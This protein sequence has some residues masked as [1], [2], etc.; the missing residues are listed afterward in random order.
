MQESQKQQE[1]R[2]QAWKQDLEEKISAQIQDVRLEQE[3]R[4]KQLEQPL[5]KMQIVILTLVVMLPITIVSTISLWLDK[6]PE[7][8]AQI[9]TNYL[10]WQERTTQ[11][12]SHQEQT[13]PKPP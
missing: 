11:S 2:L 3:S 9:Q 7:S 8:Q 4:F 13:T 6:S 5:K 10:H 1:T 12:P